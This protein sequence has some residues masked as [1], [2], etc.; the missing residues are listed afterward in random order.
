LSVI[1]RALDLIGRA[2]HRVVHPQ[3]VE[4]R[5]TLQKIS[6]AVTTGASS[7]REQLERLSKQFRGFS[8]RL[9][10]L[11]QDRD[12]RALHRDMVDL[13]YAS[14]RQRK[15]ISQGLMY[16]KWQEERRIEERRIDR[17]VETLAREKRTVLVGPWSGEVGFELLY[18]IPFVTW[19]LKRASVSPERVVIVSRGGPASWY[20]HIGGRY[21]DLFSHVTPDQF[22][23]QTEER[24]KQRTMGPFDRAMVRRIIAEGK[25]GRPFLLHPGLMY[26]LFI[27]FWKEQLTIRRVDDYSQYHTITPPVVPALAGRLPASYVAVR[28]YFSSCFPDTAENR[29]FVESTVRSLAA[30]TDVVLLNTGIRVDDHQDFTPGRESRIH[31]VDDLMTPERNLDIQTAVIAGARAFVGTY[32]G[33]SYLAPLC[34]VPALAFYSVRDAFYAVHRELAE[35]IL[36]DVNGGSLVTLDV[37]DA[38]LVRGALGAGGDLHA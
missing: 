16:A 3:A 26:K 28:F 27:P 6:R 34:G 17:R 22:R 12:L 2:V 19:A 13:R 29:A 31:T 20:S 11:A 4:E 15:M 36:R 35:R 21:I 10:A 14:A 8:Q 5:A 23:A 18:W 32:G 30:A 24:K 25:L 37:K 1:G 33:Y 7:E 9:D 38:A